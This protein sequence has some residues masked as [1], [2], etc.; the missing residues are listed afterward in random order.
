MKIQKCD[1]SFFNPLCEFF[2]EVMQNLINN[3]NYPKWI[4]GVYPCNESIKNDI[5][6]GWQYIALDGE[7]IVGAFILNQKP[8]GNY[9]KGSWAKNLA[10]G[11][12][13]VIH[14][15]ATH[16][17]EYGKGIASKMVRFALDYAKEMGYKGIR[18]DVVPTNH[19][20]NALYKKMGFNC[21]GEYDLDRGYEHIP[22]F[23][24]F[25]YNF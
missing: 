22:T 6:S 14:T 4:Y 11:E 5:D 19:P 17:N 13:L 25:E 18:L 23:L 10:E 1:A 12:Y 24:L 21:V 9:Q 8:M 16:P 3:I 20:A 15:L 7:K 2:E